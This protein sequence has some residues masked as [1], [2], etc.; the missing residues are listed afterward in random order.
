MCH[1]NKGPSIELNI[2][3]GLAELEEIDI[4]KEKSEI[5]DEGS[6]EMPQD[7]IIKLKRYIFVISQRKSV[8]SINDLRS[9]F[10]DDFIDTSKELDLIYKLQKLDIINL[11]VFFFFSKVFFFHLASSQYSFSIAYFKPIIPTFPIFSTFSNSI[12][13]EVQEYSNAMIK[14]KKIQ[15]WPLEMDQSPVY[16]VNW[17]FSRRPDRC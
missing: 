4:E 12:K 11:Q 15:C 16:V 7:L 10:K 6:V 3:S 5:S 8:F 1:L 9:K 17:N 2:D 13:E 14:L